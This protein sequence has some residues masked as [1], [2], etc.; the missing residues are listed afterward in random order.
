ML[1]LMCQLFGAWS[2]LTG[3]LRLLSSES[4]FE[5]VLGTIGVAIGVA[6]LTLIVNTAW[7]EISLRIKS[8][9][10]K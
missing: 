10:S 7:S 6:G 9:I 3:G 8:R 4:P 5:M 2:L 1:Y